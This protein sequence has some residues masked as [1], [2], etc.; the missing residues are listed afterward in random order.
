MTAQL[1]L[2]TSRKPGKLAIA[3]ILLAVVILSFLAFAI[4]TGEPVFAIKW[5]LGLQADD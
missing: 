3:G 2:P 4:Y 1:H 5:A